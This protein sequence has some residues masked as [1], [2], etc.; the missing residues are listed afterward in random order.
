MTVTSKETLNNESLEAM[1]AAS[2]P[3]IPFVVGHVA[4]Q[5]LLWSVALRRRNSAFLYATDGRRPADATALLQPSEKAGQTNV[6]LHNLILS[7]ENFGFLVNKSILRKSICGNDDQIITYRAGNRK[8][9][10][11]VV[12]YL[13]WSYGDGKWIEFNFRWTERYQTGSFRQIRFLWN[14][15]Q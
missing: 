9:E 7:C 15:K 11:L 4:Y 10:L 5:Y 8:I 1:W 6:F 2:K 3:S 14:S 12:Q 13:S